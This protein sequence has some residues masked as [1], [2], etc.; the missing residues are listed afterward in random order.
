MIHFEIDPAEIGKTRRPDVAVLGDLGLSVARLVELSLQQQV[1]PRTALGWRASPVETDLS[2]HRASTEGPSS[3]RRCCWPFASWHRMPSSPRTWVSTVWAARYLRNGPRG[4]ISS[5]G[6]GTM[7]FGMPAAMGAQV[8]CPDRR[9]VCIAGDASILMNIQELGT[10]AAYGLPVK[11][12][13][14]NNHWQGMCV[15]GRRASTRRYSASDMLNGMPDFVALA[16]SFGVD[17]VH[18]R[19]RDSLKRDLEAALKPPARC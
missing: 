8:A 9:L 4:W 6:L 14:V 10:L 19:E 2:P 17:G 11:V 15:S 3:P 18:I 16:R 12:V 5:A 13:I 7:G 1:Q